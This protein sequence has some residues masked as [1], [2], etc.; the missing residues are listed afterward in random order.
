MHTPIKVLYKSQTIFS[1]SYRH[2]IRCHYVQAEH[3]FVPRSFHVFHTRKFGK[4]W[5]MSWWCNR[6]Q[7]EKRLLVSAHVT[8]PHNGCGHWQKLLY[9]ASDYI[10]RLLISS[11]FYL[12]VLISILCQKMLVYSPVFL[13][14]SCRSS[15][16]LILTEKKPPLV[17]HHSQTKPNL[18]Q[19]LKTLH[20]YS[21]RHYGN[22]IIKVHK[23]INCLG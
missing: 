2:A 11:W 1:A 20:H 23:L 8:R 12:S 7:F 17:L 6:M 15:R 5:S 10:I 18:T 4:S 3:S 14:W 9:T 16:L 21:S 22:H 13:S 19:K